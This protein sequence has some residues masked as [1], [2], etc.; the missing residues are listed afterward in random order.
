MQRAVQQATKPSFG[1]KRPSLA[2]TGLTTGL[3]FDSEFFL[4]INP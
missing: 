4:F 3:Y 1:E 2:Y